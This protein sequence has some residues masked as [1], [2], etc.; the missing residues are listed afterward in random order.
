MIWDRQQELE[1]WN[2]QERSFKVITGGSI[3]VFVCI[4]HHFQYVPIIGT[5][6]WSR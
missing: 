1:A 4:M 5:N 3:L 6:L 2:G